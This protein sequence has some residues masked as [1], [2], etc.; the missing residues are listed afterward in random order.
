MD[1][2]LALQTLWPARAK[3]GYNL[4]KTQTDMMLPADGGQHSTIAQIATL[5][6]SPPSPHQNHRRR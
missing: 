5:D 2:S 1:Y 6:E 4:G 3:P